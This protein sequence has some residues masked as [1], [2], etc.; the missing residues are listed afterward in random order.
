[1]HCVVDRDKIED[2]GKYTTTLLSAASDPGHRIVIRQNIA[3]WSF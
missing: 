3:P 2:E 1:M